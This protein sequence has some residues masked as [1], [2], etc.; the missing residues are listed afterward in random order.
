MI[1]ACNPCVPQLSP[2]IERVAALQAVVASEPE[3]LIVLTH[4]LRLCRDEHRALWEQ[5]DDGPGRTQSIDL[6][7]RLRPQLTASDG[8]LAPT[9]RRA[10]TAKFDG[11]EG[12]SAV[13]VAHCLAGLIDE[14]Y[15]HTFAESFRQRSPYQPSAGDLVPLDNPDLPAMTSLPVTSPPWRLANQL[16]ETRRI[17]LAGGWSTESE[18]SSTTA[19]STPGHQGVKQSRCG[20]ESRRATIGPAIES[21]DSAATQ[22]WTT[23]RG[24]PRAKASMFSSVVS[25]IRCS[26]SSVL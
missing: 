8:V 6:V 16:D 12:A 9:V 4:L 24:R 20:T 5:L 21:G 1:I 10:L 26:A 3:P 22:R 23:L 25:M 17:R 19:C 18:S 14:V 15:G 13:V 11:S 7:Q 2:L